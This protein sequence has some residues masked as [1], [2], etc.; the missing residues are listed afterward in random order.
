MLIQ[1]LKIAFAMYSK[2]PMPSSR[3]TAKNMRFVLCFFPLV[4][5]V[6]SGIIF[7]WLTLT[8]NMVTTTAG[9]IFVSCIT[10]LLPLWLT[11]GIHLDGLLDTMDAR[12]CYQEPAKRLEILKDPRAGAFAV[13]GGIAYFLLYFG[14]V[15]VLVERLAQQTTSISPMLWFVCLT[16]VLS[17]SLSGLSVVLFP[18]AKNTGLAYTFASKADRVRVKWVL[19]AV[20]VAVAL[21]MLWI[22]L[23]YACAV[24][25]LTG[26]I[27]WYYHRMAV[28]EFGGITGDLCG[29]FVQKL[30]LMVAV[31]LALITLFGG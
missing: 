12:S 13:I 7:A 30:E 10:L 17:R 28:R 31:L 23:W 9:L 1:S 27:Y 2:I 26:G 22:H 16:F 4:G 18:M 24:L 20:L 11:G 29:W 8:Q 5:V 25:L 19:I 6:I 21:A 15:T 14:S 3:W